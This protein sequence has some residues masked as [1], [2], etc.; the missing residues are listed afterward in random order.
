MRPV[1]F[2]DEYPNRR[3]TLRSRT[4]NVSRRAVLAGCASLVALAALSGT[5]LW[6]FLSQDQV[7]LKLLAEQTAQRRSYE[8]KLLALRTRLDEVSS[9]RMVEQQVLEVR[10]QELLARQAALEARQGRVQ[11]LADR[12]GASAAGRAR[13][14]LSREGTGRAGASGPD[15]PDRADPAKPRLRET[16]PGTPGRRAHL[17]R[18]RTGLDDAEQGLARI[19]SAQHRSLE[20]AAAEAA[21]E[22]RRFETAIRTVGLNPSAA[23]LPGVSGTGGPLVPATAEGSFESLVQQAEIGLDRLSRLRR[24]ASALPFGEPIRGEIDLSSGFGYRLDPFTRGPAMHT[25]LDFKAAHGAPARAAGAGRVVSAEPAGAYGNMVEIEHAHGVTSRYAH[26]AAI[27]VSVGQ[28][29]K[30]GAV[31]GR[32]GSTGRST[33]PHLHY[34]T[35]LNGEP[36]D[37]Q[38]F[39]RAGAS[40]A[41]LTTASR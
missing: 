15:Q 2:L 27:A 21:L 10:L 28:E 33:G 30:Q 5:S 39:L 41:P 9:Q 31:L 35:R 18:L 14:E 1:P 12:A 3:R 36:V 38:L 34:E 23:E 37:P 32:V 17:D 29:V 16:E 22:A 26:L 25:G 6:Y 20:T 19:A 24:V 8:D 40:V 7:V 13:G 11:S 4:V